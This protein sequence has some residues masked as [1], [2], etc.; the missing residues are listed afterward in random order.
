MLRLD[1]HGIF[2][3]GPYDNDDSWLRSLPKGYYYFRLVCL[4][5]VFLFQQEIIF[6]FSNLQKSY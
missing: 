2:L 3:V 1:L 6:I 5:V 4:Y